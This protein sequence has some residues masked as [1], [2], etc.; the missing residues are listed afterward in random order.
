MAWGYLRMMKNL[1]IV[2]PF[3]LSISCVAQQDTEQF[4]WNN[5]RFE[6]VK[7]Y[8]Y[9]L[10]RN[11]EM[12]IIVN[13]VLNKTAVDTTGVELNPSQIDRVVSVVTGMN[14][15]GEDPEFFCFIPH[16]GI[17]FYD[18]YNRPLAHIS[19]CL[20][21][22]QKR[23]YPETTYHSRGMGILKEVILELGLPVFKRTEE[24][25][26]YGESLEKR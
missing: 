8:L 20:S 10:S 24:Y 23:V 4:D 15:A 14:S 2:I 7:A 1:L 16:H 19:I 22:H 6:K 11:P 26:E 3:C 17:V 21:C 9:G 25:M 5:P 13:G 18:A 12:D